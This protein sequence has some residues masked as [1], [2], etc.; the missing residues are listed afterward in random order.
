[1]IAPGTS[2]HRFQLATRGPERWLLWLRRLAIGCFVALAATPLVVDFAARDDSFMG[3]K[4]AWIGIITALGIAAVLARAVAGRPAMIPLNLLF[5]LAIIFCAWHWVAVLWAPSRSLGVDAAAHTTWFT[6]ALWLGMQ[7][8]K[9]RRWLIRLGWAL[10]AVGAITAA[11]TLTEDVVRAFY[12]KHVWVHP[13][14]PDWRGYLAAGLGNTSHIGDLLALAMIPALIF[15]GE[16]RRRHAL[17]I[18]GVSSIVL[19]AALIVVFSAGSSL[20]LVVGAVVMLIL[21]LIHA[22]P[23][24]FM[25]RWLRWTI[26]VVGWCFVVGFF[27]TDQRWNPHRPSILKQGFGS[28]RW[29]EG[30]P[31]RLAIWAGTLEMVRLHPIGGIGAG[32]YTYVFPEM[33]SALVL[34][35]PNLEVYQGKYTNAAHNILMQAWAE[36][37]IVGLALLAALLASMYYVLLYDLN[38][39]R[40]SG[41][42]IRVTLAGLLTAWLVQGQVN[43][44][45]QTPVG[46]LCLYGI[47]LAI[48]AERAGRGDPRLPP[49][50]FET[51]W[52]AIRVDWR[53]MRQPTALGVAA[54]LPNGVAIAF[55]AIFLVGALIYV[56]HALAPLRAQ[57]EYRRGQIAEDF[58][59]PA[60]EQYFQ[61]GLRIDPN[62]QDLR[63]HYSS[64]LLNHGRPAECIEQLKIVRK[65]LNSSE[66][67]DR[68]AHAYTMLG[69]HDK[70]A[71][72]LEQLQKRKTPGAAK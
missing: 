32:N 72:A 68:E 1:M 70:A 52:V 21:V 45:L 35:R 26:L 43:F 34:G 22:G 23:R 39:A 10:I 17:W 64:W 63:S 2:K 40:R 5:L 56:P 33:H 27:T 16:A 67:Y 13:N 9:G 31:T 25:R 29:Q 19:P 14:L 30:G 53:T 41:L 46:A 37:G 11:W 58:H 57:R 59:S 66:L 20:G 28:E 18:C 4:W 6:V 49:L 7:I 65:R 8:V 69:Q 50:R 60:A 48:I 55:G 3:P 54:L 15:Y 61:E 62:A 36:L 44:V 12:P 42:L 71:Q 24:W 38:R 51:D 47:L